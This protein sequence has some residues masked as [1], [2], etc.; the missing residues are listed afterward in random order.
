MHRICCEIA[1]LKFRGLLTGR[2]SLRAV[3]AVIGLVTICLIS[4]QRA[5]AADKEYVDK[6]GQ[7][8]LIAPFTPPTLAE[9]DAKADWQAKPVLD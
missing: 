7:P 3:T 8:T 2:R 4:A 9:L 1:S 5:T 6:N